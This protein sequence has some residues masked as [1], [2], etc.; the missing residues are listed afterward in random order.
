MRRRI[1]VLAIS[2]MLLGL[3]GGVAY[4]YFTSS[5][6]GTGSASTGTMQTVTVAA[7]TGSPTTPLIPEGSGDVALQVTN[8]NGFA[9]T[10]VSVTGSGGITVDGGHS[11]CDPSVVTFTDQT[12]LT[13]S[14]PADS[15]DWQVYLPGAAS[16]S[17]AAANACQGATFS[18]P[19]TITVHK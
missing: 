10:L 4:A 17:S 16:M 18:I 12:G 9:V 11:G 19:V 3:T 15:T 13:I 8:P 2:A 5:G 1:L 6:S 7:S 14:I